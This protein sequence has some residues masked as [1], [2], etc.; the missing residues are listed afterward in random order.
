M[1]SIINLNYRGNSLPIKEVDGTPWINLNAMG[2]PFGKEPN[3]WLRSETAQEYILAVETLDFDETNQTAK[4]QSGEIKPKQA[5]SIQNGGK[6]PGTWAHELVALAFAQ[7]CDASFHAWCNQQLRVLILKGE[8]KIDMQQESLKLRW[9]KT[10]MMVK[11]GQK[12]GHRFITFLQECEKPDGSR[13]PRIRY[14]DMINRLFSHFTGESYEFK[15]DVIHKMRDNFQTYKKEYMSR[16]TNKGNIL[17]NVML[18]DV[19]REL[20]NMWAR[21][22]AS[23]RAQTMRR[24]KEESK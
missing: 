4:T 19:E 1:N 3:Q 17:A 8:H 18:I 23:S 20:E 2:R 10:L 15:K 21:Y 5:I 14:S 7:H 12:W 9:N 16:E 11:Q 24:I 22:E 13:D 6:N